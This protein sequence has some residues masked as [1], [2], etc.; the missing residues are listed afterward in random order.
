MPEWH[1]QIDSQNHSRRHSKCHSKSHPTDIVP[2]IIP[3]VTFYM[4]LKGTSNQYVFAPSLDNS[5]PGQR[6]RLEPHRS[7][8]EPRRAIRGASHRRR[9]RPHLWPAQALIARPAISRKAS[10]SAKDFHRMVRPLQHCRRSRSR[11]LSTHTAHANITVA[12]G[13]PHA[14]VGLL[15]AFPQVCACQSSH[16]SSELSAFGDGNAVLTKV[17]SHATRSKD[18]EDFLP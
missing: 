6:V 15:L 8:W 18:W 13:A 17:P 3:K 11:D 7:G 4:A 9:G 10:T 1:S 14:C 12:G 5:L 2:T 16:A